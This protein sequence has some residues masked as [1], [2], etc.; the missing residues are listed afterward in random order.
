M[1]KIILPVILLCLIC[2]ARGEEKQD[3]LIVHEWG[4][5]TSLQDE[6]GNAIGGINADDEQLP[7]FVHQLAYYLMLPP[8]GAGSEVPVVPYAS[9]G[10]TPRCHPDVTM[11]LETPVI[12]FHPPE[13]WKS[14]PVDVRV[15]FS[16]GWLSEFYPDA[17]FKAPGFDKARP[18]GV[19]SNESVGKG[20]S[21][22]GHIKP[23]TSGELSWKGLVLGAEGAGPESKEKVWL[24]PR[25]VKAA[26]V[27][28]DGGEI[29]KFLFYRGVANADAPLRITRSKDCTTLE[30]HDNRTL[31]MPGAKDSLQ[32][33]AAWLLDVRPDGTCAFK[34][35][36]KVEEGGSPRVGMPAAFGA[37]D[38]SPDN[39]Q[40][41]KGEMRGALLNEGLYGDEADALLNTWE[42]SYFKSPGLRFFYLCP[43]IDIDNA[44]PLTVS[45][46]GGSPEILA[47]DRV[48][49]VTRVMIGRIEIVTP[50]QRALLKEI[51]SG[52]S[53]KPSFQHEA[54]VKL[55]RFRNALV[56]D[57]QKHR[58]TPA[59]AEFIS[60]NDLAAYKAD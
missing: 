35:M 40:R 10:I 16:G 14:Q 7:A 27:K 56:L 28:T 25:D 47:V 41:L 29:E 38:Y 5:F 20:F 37:G 46:P 50:E 1:N 23:N 24:A 59:L 60:K 43:R 22:I 6:K 52:G 54:Y 39:L 36:G 2:A 9:K 48:A 12:Y 8:S 17:A 19:Y 31:S 21:G 51:A 33:H 42:V 13:G 15:T 55:G 49:V 57:E 58:P 11:R 30:V 18:D 32:I 26:T 44:L 3:K 45:V 34:S 4:T 53:V